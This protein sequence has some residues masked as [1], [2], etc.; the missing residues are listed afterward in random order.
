[1]LAGG[2]ERLSIAWDRAR[3]GVLSIRARPPADDNIAEAQEFFRLVNER[4]G[5][6]ATEP[7]SVG[8]HRV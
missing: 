1:L 6:G 7:L 5:A 2:A 3:G 8:D 4:S